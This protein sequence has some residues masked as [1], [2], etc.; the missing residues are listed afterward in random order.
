MKRAN[1]LDD[2]E[3]VENFRDGDLSV[4]EALLNQYEATIFRLII[5]LVCNYHDAQEL[6]QEVFIKVYQKLHFFQG[7]SKLIYWIS[8]IA[9]HQSINFLRR[10]SLVQFISMEWL[11]SKKLQD[12]EDTSCSSNVE[13]TYIQ[14][15]KMQHLYAVLGTLPFQQREI[16]VLRELQKMSYKD[17]SSI[18]GISIGTVKSRLSRSKQ[19][20]KTKLEVAS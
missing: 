2:K 3:I 4:F 17:I 11:F 19:S 7:S 18:L 9:R 15:E 12:L 16:I 10:K 8:Q 13:E 20:L 6:T 1:R 5:G 14:K